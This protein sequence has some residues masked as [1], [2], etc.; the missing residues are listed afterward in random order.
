MNRRNYRRELE[1]IIERDGE[2]R[3]SVL[4][5]SCCGPCSTAVL[6]YLTEHFNVTLLWYNPNLYP[7]SEYEK[8]FSAQLEVIERMGFKDRVPVI[9]L[10]YTPEDYVSAVRGLEDEPEGGARCR[11][12]FRIRLKKCAETAGKLNF[13]YFCTTLTVSR[14][15]NAVVINSVA[16]EEAELAG[17]RWLPSDFKKN[18]GENRS[19]EISEELGIYRQ[20]YCGCEYSLK[21][22]EK[23]AENHPEKETIT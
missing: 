20:L 16:E 14:H 7:E 19:V 4:L 17:V 8:R 1:K 22:R 10:E 2:T 11:E 6:E 9:R 5:H 13:D 23:Y 18:N 12:C 21:N 3:P 15:K